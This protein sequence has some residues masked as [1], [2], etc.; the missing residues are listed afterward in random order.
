MKIVAEAGPCNG[1]LAY[2]LDAVDAVAEAGAW[3]F[4][5]QMYNPETIATADAVTYDHLNQPGTLQR[6]VFAETIP[7][8]QWHQ[9]QDRCHTRGL[10]FFASCFDEEA[11]T[12]LA[13]MGASYIK[14]ASGD[15]THGPL[16]RHIA[17]SGIPNVILSTGASQ[18]GEILDALGVL[19]NVRGSITLLA[20]TLEYPATDGLMGRIEQLRTLFPERKVGYSDHT[21][22]TTTTYIATTLGVEMLEKHFTL[23]PGEGGD[24]DFAATP[25]MLTEMVK[26]ENQVDAMLFTPSPFGPTPEESEARTGARRGAYYARGMEKGELLGTDPFVYLRPVH[27]ERFTPMQMMRYLDQPWFLLTDVAA[28]DPFRIKDVDQ[29]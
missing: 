27:D 25:E 5:V 21:Y 12:V 23:T 1:D 16:L 3:G 9:V 17:D 6:D 28:G 8:D 14:V 29:P 15:I 26:I 22:G 24:H 20:C 18:Y 19:R 13:E 4:K 7:Y 11:V 10:I 2:A